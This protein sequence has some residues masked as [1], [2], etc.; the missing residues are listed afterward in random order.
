M[1]GRA[2]SDFAVLPQ[3]QL[4]LLRL[5]LRLPVHRC[6]AQ[7]SL[8]PVAR[9]PLHSHLHL[10]LRLHLHLHLHLRPLPRRQC[11]PL[12]Q[13]SAWGQ[14]EYYWTQRRAPTAAAGFGFGGASPH[15][16]SARVHEAMAPGPR[17]EFARQRCCL[18][19]RCRCRLVHCRCHRES[20]SA[21]ASMRHDRVCGGFVNQPRHGRWLPPDTDG[22][23]AGNNRLPSPQKS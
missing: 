1:E 9:P 20:W 23:C 21:S 12:P 22:Q 5:C 15:C 7:G 2:D 10:R 6:S 8:L 18:L 14:P 3:P 17:A 13:Q 16:W 4:Q 11:R 19:C